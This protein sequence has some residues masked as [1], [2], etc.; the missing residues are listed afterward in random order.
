M[1]PPKGKKVVGYY[2]FPRRGV[3]AG[4][5]ERFGPDAE[6]VDLDL[7]KFDWLGD[8]SGRVAANLLLLLRQGWPEMVAFGGRLALFAVGGSVLVGGVTALL[9]WVLYLVVAGPLMRRCWGTG[10]LIGCLAVS[11]V[12]LCA[13]S[14]GA[15]RD[16]R[17]GA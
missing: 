2:G 17:C 15:F 10:R 7:A 3:L 6:L 8:E 14:G 13:G 11:I 4:A 16:R 9:A 12:V 5:R 1:I